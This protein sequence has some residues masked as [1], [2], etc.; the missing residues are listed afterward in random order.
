M[1]GNKLSAKAGEEVLWMENAILQLGNLNRK[2]EEYAAA[3]KNADSL[4][5]PIVRTLSNMRQQGMIKNLGVVA[6]QAGMLAVSAM[7]GSQ[8][9]R[10]RTLRDGVANFKIML[11]RVIKATID[12][13]ARQQGE[14]HAELEKV[15]A[16]DLAARSAKP[17]AI[18]GAAPVAAAKPEVAR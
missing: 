10:T 7:R 18:A 13:D 16:A 2:I 5:Q 3:K 11:T 9:Q 14:K 1:A 15:K 12:A 8:M 4:L 6:D 17:V